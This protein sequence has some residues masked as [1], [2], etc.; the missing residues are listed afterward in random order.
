M[1]GPIIV[2]SRRRFGS[3]GAVHQS[4]SSSAPYSIMHSRTLNDEM[5]VCANITEPKA[6]C[7]A[8]VRASRRTQQRILP[9][10]SIGNDPPP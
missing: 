9:I 1:G 2:R 5:N 7:K 10:A 6:K 3:A 4:S 8:I